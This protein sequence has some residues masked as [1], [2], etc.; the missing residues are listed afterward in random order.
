V[1]ALIAIPL[2]QDKISA[3]LRGIGEEHDAEARDDE[4]G[5]AMRQF[6]GRRV[7]ERKAH[8]KACGCAFPCALKHRGGDV[9]P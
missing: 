7:A 4:I 9:E 6:V 8:R 1:A 5:P 3:R 2:W